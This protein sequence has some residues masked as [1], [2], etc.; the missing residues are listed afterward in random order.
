MNIR[1]LFDL[2]IIAMLAIV[3]GCT[4]TDGGFEA[5]ISFCDDAAQCEWENSSQNEGAPGDF[6]EG[7]CRDKC[8]FYST[9]G[10]FVVRRSTACEEYDSEAEVCWKQVEQEEFLRNV[11]G[12]AVDRYMECLVD[13]GAWKCDSGRYEMLIESAEECSSYAKCID[14]LGDSYIPTPEWNNGQCTSAPEGNETFYLDI[15]L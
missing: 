13:L 15:V 3:Y 5:C 6:Y 12:A 11:G 8:L 9:N 7:Q 1:H 10:A 2:L 14:G 4:Q